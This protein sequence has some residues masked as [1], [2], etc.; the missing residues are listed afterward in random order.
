MNDEACIR[1]NVS[2]EQ[3]QRTDFLHCFFL[4]VSALLKVRREAEA[5]R[6]QQEAQE[7]HEAEGGT[8]T[9][10][11]PEKVDWLYGT[12]TPPIGDDEEVEDE[13]DEL[14]TSNRWQDDPDYLAKVSC[15]PP[16]EYRS[17]HFLSSIYM[18]FR[19]NN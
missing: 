2:I 11:E 6:A 3:C 14:V 17:F 13:R 7:K 8:G 19:G 10:E 16:E 4:P 1:R 12:R 5:R 15:S 18:H 9:V